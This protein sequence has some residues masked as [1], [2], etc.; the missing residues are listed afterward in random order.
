[1]PGSSAL[2]SAG[3]SNSVHD[4]CYHEFSSDLTHT[5]AGAPRTIHENGFRQQAPTGSSRW[6]SFTAVRAIAPMTSQLSPARSI[7][8]TTPPFQAIGAGRSNTRPGMAVVRGDRARDVSHPRSSPQA[9]IVALLVAAGPLA[10]WAAWS[11]PKHPPIRFSERH[12]STLEP[13]RGP[14]ATAPRLPGSPRWPPGRWL[15]SRSA[16][17]SPACAFRLPW[18]CHRSSSLPI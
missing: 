8:G 11:L 5:L 6:R 18:V 17:R 7:L 16:S 2:V 3:S 14:W 1:M 4:S 13:D 10:S 9:R 15:R 12:P